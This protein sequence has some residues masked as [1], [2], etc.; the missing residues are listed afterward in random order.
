MAVPSSGRGRDRRTVNAF[1]LLFAIKG[2][3]AVVAV[4]L[5]SWVGWD[6][7]QRFSVGDAVVIDGDTLRIEAT[8]FRLVGIDAPE[9]KQTCGVKK[10]WACGLRAKEALTA[11]VRMRAIVCLHRGED[12]YGR[13]LAL[14][15]AGTK[16]VGELMVAKGLAITYGDRG[17]RYEAVQ[18]RAL[19]SLHGIW[20]TSFELP[21]E[22]RRKH[23]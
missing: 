21:S 10:R 7:W 23:R 2:A 1:R 14:C 19:R 4:L 22:Y 8:T 12:V 11:L 3:T 15:Y 18:D 6:V 5:F 9:L 13:V 16:D 17:H 20:R